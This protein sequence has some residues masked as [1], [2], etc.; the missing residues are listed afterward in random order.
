MSSIK[1][2]ERTKVIGLVSAIAVVFGIG[3]I[4]VAKQAGLFGRAA[5]SPAKDTAAAPVP[6]PAVAPAPQTAVAPGAPLTASGIPA[7]GQPMP[8]MAEQKTAVL[9][10]YLSADPFR[11]IVAEATPAPVATPAPAAP[12]VTVT[13]VPNSGALPPGGFPFGVNARPTIT[14]V[15]PAPVPEP[16]MELIGVITGTD[17][18]A[19]IRA[20]G[21]E[22]FL[23]R[24][25]VVN[26]YRIV[27]IDDD[28]VTLRRGKVGRI[29][30]V[31]TTGS[32]MV[33]LSDTS[34]RSVPAKKSSAIVQPHLALQKPPLRTATPA[35]PPQPFTVVAPMTHSAAAAPILI[36][37]RDPEPAPYEPAAPAATPA[38][39]VP[40]PTATPVVPVVL[41]P[42]SP[43]VPADLPPSPL[44]TPAPL[45]TPA[46]VPPAPPVVRD[47]RAR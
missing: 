15:L 34:V 37:V 13:Q 16:P 27:R 43:P 36:P 28:T 35:P 11:P 40:V 4:N 44:P 47:N 7:A 20:G 25:Q 9:P 29:L 1:P 26:G 24:G 17:A 23:H 5:P 2:E 19:M 3:G 39:F 22:R 21:G 10:P 42:V 33:T 46:V 32:E 45:E 12:R 30:R 18:I 38:P 6:L 41:D 14:A 31:G 8:A